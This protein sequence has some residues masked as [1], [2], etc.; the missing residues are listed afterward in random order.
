MY[1][2]I[3]IKLNNKYT[4]SKPF[5]INIT[6][7]DFIAQILRDVDYSVMLNE[8]EE[9]TLFV[10]KYPKKTSYINAN[11][12][13]N[14]ISSFEILGEYT[15]KTNNMNHEYSIKNMDKYTLTKTLNNE[16]NTTIRFSII[17]QKNKS[18][19]I[20]SLPTIIGNIKYLE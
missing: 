9:F 19:C 10:I 1:I 16:L 6:D 20:L 7:N 4:F 18:N 3:C 8:S 5:Y 14:L 12:N 13:P 15:I 2:G 11:E 17:K